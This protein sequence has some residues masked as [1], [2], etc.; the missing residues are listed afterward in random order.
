MTW[1]HWLV[2]ASVLAVA[3]IAVALLLVRRP[4]CMF[5][6]WERTIGVELEAQVKD[7]ESVKTKL[8]ITDSQTRQYDRL[9]QDF[10]LKYDAACS[11]A[12]AD[13]P[14]MKQDE[15]TCLRRNMD[16]VLDQI[17]QFATAVE[18]A[19][20]LA[21]PSSQR[22]V[23]QKAL[24]ALEEA[25]RENYR[26]GCTTAVIVNPKALDFVANTLE[27]SI[28]ITNGGN[29]DFTFTIEAYPTG[30]D[31]KPPSGKVEVG[32]TA[33]VAI[34][35]TRLPVGTERPLTLHVRTNFNDRHS[36]VLNVDEKNAA[37]WETVGIE[38]TNIATR[39]GR[40]PEVDDAVQA[41]ERFVGPRSSASVADKYV[42][43]SSGLLEV[44]ADAE[45]RVSLARATALDPAVSNDY[46]VLISNGV[47][48]R[49]RPAD[50]LD[51]FTQARLAAV[52]QTHGEALANL[53][54]GS[55]FYTRGELTQARQLFSSG[56]SVPE[57]Q[58]LQL[59]EFASGEICETDAVSCRAGIRRSAN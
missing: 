24:A 32:K 11:D 37:V 8:G 42:L 35:R 48:N 46:W 1:K 5:S 10:A 56:R 55:L 45:A 25:N 21:D 30:F 41:I 17:R 18:A 44:G 19:K 43:A 29:N 50:A 58:R 34:F 52:P 27:R 28:Q 13:P 38:I 33:S 2:I 26:S 22:E 16:Y 4:D 36:V 14:R 57:A 53:L 49:D 7:L 20:S 23:I 47:A 3:G 40:A 6:G 15:Y 31:P 9:M 39:A 54:S 51:Y 59:L 12:S